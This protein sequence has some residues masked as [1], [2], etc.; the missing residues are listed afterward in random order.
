MLGMLVREIDMTPLTQQLED[1]KKELN[2]LVNN[3]KINWYNGWEKGTTK[4]EERLLLQAEIAILE[5]AIAEIKKKDEIID[6]YAETLK[7]TNEKN[8]TEM[9]KQRQEILD[10]I[11]QRKKVYENEKSEVDGTWDAWFELRQVELFI[12]QLNQPK[13]EKENSKQQLTNSEGKI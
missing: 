4:R 5:Q 6:F 9:Q 1:K 3:P 11:R 13:T 10:E 12:E 2:G 7:E 8:K